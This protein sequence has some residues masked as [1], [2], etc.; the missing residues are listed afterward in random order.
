MSETILLDFKQSCKYLDTTTIDTSLDYTLFNYDDSSWDIG[1]APFS[2]VAVFDSITYPLPEG[3]TNIAGT[4]ITQNKVWTRKYFQGNTTDMFF[5]QIPI[6]NDIAV[7]A[8]LNETPLSALL[9][10]FKYFDR[11]TWHDITGLVVDGDNLL[12]IAGGVTG[13]ADSCYND[14]KILRVSYKCKNLAHKYWR[15]FVYNNNGDTQ[16]ISIAELQM[17]TTMVDSPNIC[18]FGDDASASTN[19]TT[20]YASNAFQ[21][22]TTLDY[23]DSCISQGHEWLSDRYFITNQWLQYS[24]NRPVQISKII[25]NGGG[26]VE[27]HRTYYPKDFDLQYSDDEVVWNT[28]LSITNA[29]WQ[30]KEYVS[31]S[32]LIDYLDCDIPNCCVPEEMAVENW[33]DDNIYQE[34]PPPPTPPAFVPVFK[35]TSSNESITLP[36]TSA[37]NNYTVDWGDGSPTE[38]IV[39]TGTPSHSYSSANSYNVEITGTCPIWNFSSVNT[40]KNKIINVIQWGEIEL[41]TAYNMFYF[42][43]NLITIT[44]TDVFGSG[45]FTFR[46]MFRSS[47][48]VSANFSNWLISSGATWTSLQ[49]MF[50][51]CSSLETLDVYNWDTSK[52]STMYSTWQGCGKLVN[53][54]ISPNWDTARCGSFYFTFA[55]C[56]ALLSLD[57]RNWDS[58]W[59]TSCYY[60]FGSCTSMLTLNI[61]NWGGSIYCSDFDGMV[62]DCNLLTTFTATAPWST[63]NYT[64]FPRMFQHCWAL[65]SVDL[66]SWDVSRVEDFN[67]MF[68]YCYALTTVDLSTWTFALGD[69][70]YLD[71]MFDDCHSLTT[72]DLSTWNFSSGFFGMSNF[73]RDCW[74]LP[75]SVIISINNWD[76]SNVEWMSLMFYNCASLT[77]VDLD[78]W[79][80]TS[81]EYTDQMFVGC[82][83]LHSI[84]VSTW[85][86]SNV[87]EFG[88]MFAGCVALPSINLGNWVTT[89]VY[90]Y[91]S[92]FSS[93]YLLGWVH[94]DSWNTIAGRD[95]SGMF[96]GCEVLTC[97]TTINTTLA[98]DT[99][100]MFGGCVLL[101]TPSVTDQALILAG[102]NWNG[103]GC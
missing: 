60:T 12:A 1:L 27:V 9:A 73:F 81:L 21:L 8:Y 56:Y 65:I 20:Y 83:A 22:G 66:S 75:N 36:T 70:T 24:F 103:G 17:F 45:I 101:S 49:E 90:D 68:E 86:M 78:G 53:F 67:E 63:A 38:D 59:T 15:I 89:S 94:N 61:D 26:G 88:H 2:T 62:A 35:T 74:V 47:G 80:T 71:W 39:G 30:L 98:T 19:L 95:F 54:N 93:C 64:W 51:N 87:F 44:A 32:V 55:Y 23:C 102:T 11:T 85:D 92:M 29:Y 100:S 41:V 31:Y 57:L 6:Y 46:G 84:S 79:T 3:A 97:F 77:S 52:V 91:S 48:L 72:I 10:G 14:S 82:S 25:C 99:S 50:L 18:A 16:F 37:N 58:G 4:V 7:T 69:Y 42:C 5:A 33:P 13:G 76:V 28:A 43:S 96:S 40:S 34:P